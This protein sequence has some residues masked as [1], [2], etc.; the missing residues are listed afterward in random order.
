MASP[1]EQCDRHLDWDGC[2]NVRDLGGIP[3][4]GGR[5]VGRGA[6]VR[7]DSLEKLSSAGWQALHEHGV[8]T[9][10]DL[11]ND[12][13]RE[14]DAAPR[15]PDLTTLHLPL[16]NIEAEDFWKGKWATGPQFG[17]P[18]YYRA[19]I[20]RFPERSAR[21]LA[22][23]AN[24]EPGG[25]VVHCVGGR[26]RTGQTAMLALSLA[27]VAPAEIV[28]DYELSDPRL[29]GLWE[30]LGEENPTPAIEAFL[31]EH[32]TTAGEIIEATLSSIDLEATLR[33]GGL[34][35]E[36]ITTLRKRLL[37]PA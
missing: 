5:V 16:D 17:T 20:L 12:D 22:A 8:R 13:E 3:A 37:E 1:G 23:I 9:I 29:A 33:D 19:H 24:A 32:G 18:L 35:A 4:A 10:V 28:A 14:Q 6:L 2:F 21:V 27:G 25:V 7:A 26:D 30:A 31:T 11:R 36:D 34:A 15:P